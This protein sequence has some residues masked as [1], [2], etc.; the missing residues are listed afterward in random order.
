MRYS[1]IYTD[2]VKRYY[3]EGFLHREDY[4]AVEYDNGN[5]Y[6]FKNGMRHRENGPAIEHV[7]GSKEWWLN[8][9]RFGVNNDFTNESWKIFVKTLIFS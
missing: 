4:P 6:W 3:E 8:H 2:G 1:I 7:D 5:K 9:E